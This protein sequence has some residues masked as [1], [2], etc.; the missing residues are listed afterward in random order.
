MISRQNSG[1]GA[2]AVRGFL[3]Q[4]LVALL[5]VAKAGHSLSEIT[6]EPKF[7]NEQFDFVW[8][9]DSGSHAVQVKSTSNVF[10]KSQVE[11][12][13]NK[14]ETARSTEDCVLMLVGIFH[15]N[16]EKINRVG[17]VTIKKKNVDIPGLLNEAAQGVSTLWQMAEMPPRH[18]SENLLVAKALVTQLEFYSTE[19]RTLSGE[20]FIDLMCNWIIQA[21]V[22]EPRVDISR[23]IKSA[24][25][26]L[27]GRK[28]DIKRL[29]GAWGRA[30]RGK[31]E[32]PHVLTFVALGGEGKTSIVA[33]WL[34]ELAHKN[35]LGCDAVF[36]WSFYDQGTDEKT[37]GSSDLF[38]A[39]ALIFFGDES[40]AR[41]AQGALEKGRRLAQ[42]VGERRSLLVLDGLEPLQYAFD[43]PTP[44]ELKDPGIA[45]LLKELAAINRGLCVVTTRYSIP[46]LSAY[47]QTT[48]PEIE[49][50]RLSKE[51]GVALLRSLGVKT[52]SKNDFEE[53]VED[54]D[55]H[56][57]TLQIIGGFLARAF[58]GDIRLRDRL[59]FEIADNKIRGGHAFRA[60]DSYV[61][62]MKNENEEARREL[63]FLRLLG[64]FDRPATEDCV[65]SLVAPPAIHKMTEPL[66]G[67]AEEDREFSLT[68]LEAAKLLTLNRDAA[69]V[70]LSIDSHPLIREY[71]AKQ[72]REDSVRDPTNEAWRTAHRRL[73]EHLCEST[74][75]EPDARLE[76]LQPLYQAVTHGCKA[77]LQQDACDNVYLARILR[78]DEYYSANKLGAFGSNLGA[79]ASFF[80]IP[81]RCV[82]PG[83]TEGN[84]AELFGEAAFCLRALGRLAEAHEPMHATLLFME[85]QRDWKQAAI[86]ASNLS[87][88]ELTLGDVPGAV[89]SATQSVTYADRSGDAYWKVN[90]R[91]ALADALHHAGQRLEAK[92][93]FREAEALQ[94]ER[95]PEYNLLYS[96]GGFQ[97]CDLL[98]TEAELCTW[99]VFLGSNRSEK[100]DPEYEPAA[101]DGGN[102]VQ[103]LLTSAATSIQ[104]CRLVS[105][106][107]AQT[108]QWGG[109][110]YR[111]SLLHVAL[112]HL[113]MGRAAL[114]RLVLESLIRPAE[115]PQAFLSSSLGLSSVDCI[116]LTAVAKLLDAAVD[117]LRRS[118]QAQELPR[119]LLT[120]AL[121]SALEGNC[122]G[123]RGAQR[124]L[125]E[126]W[127]IAARGPM[128][129]FLADIHLHRARLFGAVKY[130]W[131]SPHKDLAEA[132]RLIEKLGYLRRMEELKYAETR[133]AK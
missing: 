97:Y 28:R 40:M 27:I 72:L 81:W 69:G 32:R 59:D 22:Q 42:L 83:L 101:C 118:G 87:E 104:S 110:A 3:I 88:L 122:T 93:C 56:A 33:K 13:A 4:T 9:D 125:D 52:G 15:P 79:V 55:G 76:D 116:A 75:D 48:S 14:M 21:P 100:A 65:L 103:S 99:Q 113:T 5:E 60:M 115:S 70:T 38:L 49:L 1:G 77:G 106:R 6:L 123:P 62:W 73:Y 58:H 57:L 46:D 108:L 2:V 112:D 80:D 105:E 61:K 12:W 89:V 107:A 92:A 91:T 50:K 121:L 82:S 47:W 117:D 30:V 44:G 41:S 102:E 98:L 31:Q 43:S 39:D 126:A 25:A 90:G 68:A 84:K 74:K 11:Q 71:F 124:N 36:A 29:N 127:E 26:E 19:C 129:L 133:L 67:L 63:A 95:R 23:V 8:K 128:P 54:V 86:A 66:V 51:A 132:R 111:Q 96:L 78:R 7:G 18:A 34:A 35:W 37:A 10:K 109:I 120:R 16:L 94:A 24:P 114:Y 131:D 53:L 45:T 130:P 17:R 20:A 119:G 64:L 85:K